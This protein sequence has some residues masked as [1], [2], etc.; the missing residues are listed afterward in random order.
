MSRLILHITTRAA[1]GGGALNLDAV[2]DVLPFAEGE[3][4]FALPAAVRRPASG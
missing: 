3:D 4:G 1:W 2:V